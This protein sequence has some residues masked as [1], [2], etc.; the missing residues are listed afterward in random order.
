MPDVTFDP[1]DQT[2]LL[3][4]LAL[5]RISPQWADFLG[6]VSGALRAQLDPGEYRQFLVRLGE[7]FASQHPLPA[8]TGLNQ[9]SD[10]MNSVW[11]PM[12]WGYT[13]V[14]DQGRRLEVI[15]RAC[16]LPAALQ[17]DVDVAGGFLE[18]VYSVWL[19]V[20]G[21]SDE[22]VLTQMAASEMPMHM[23]FVLCAGQ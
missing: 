6:L 11:A 22:L 8:C 13:A 16:P 21:A 10:A 14:S 1:T 23:A 5:E 17:I 7:E 19:K 3:H 9:L 20:A 2:E 15:H 12:R 4:S 18:G